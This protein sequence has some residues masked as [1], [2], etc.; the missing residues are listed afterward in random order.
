MTTTDAAWRKWGERD[1]YFGVVTHDEY[2]ADRI[3]ENFDAFFNTGRHEIA[4]VLDQI[5][6]QYGA[7]A[8]TRAL[9][10]GSGVGRLVLPLAEIFDQVVGV[11]IS[12]AM[13][14]EARKNAARAGLQR[15]EFV[16]S[17]DALSAVTGKFDLVHSYITLQHIPI[18]RGLAI[19]NRLLGALNP[20][21]VAALHYSVQRYLSAPKALAYAVKHE[22]PF[23]RYVL[24]L[25]Q[26]RDWDAP[27]MQMNNYPIADLMRTF[28]SNGLRDV[29]LLP[30]WQGPFLTMRVFGRKASA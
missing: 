1:P 7:I 30:E 2:R 6:R 22:V 18:E 15:V 26:R 10:F 17:D 9:D 29:M 21:G 16:H 27:A 5:K 3:E 14:A 11:D 23:G 19:T 24:N 4:T 13:H 25:M 28:K 8:T 20:G 12:E